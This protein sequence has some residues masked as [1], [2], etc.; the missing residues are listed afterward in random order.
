MPSNKQQ[1]TFAQSKDIRSDTRRVV[2]R[3]ESHLPKRPTHKRFA[4]GSC[5]VDY[6]HSDQADSQIRAYLP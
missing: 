1:P 5:N 6:Q 4:K 2:V 3:V